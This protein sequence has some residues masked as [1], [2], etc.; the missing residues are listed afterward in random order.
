MRRDD[1]LDLN[2]ALQHP[3]RKIAV[4]LSTELPAEEDI[5]LVEPLE[6]FLEAVSTGNMLLITGEFKTKCVL[7]CSRCGAPIPQ[8]VAFEMDEQ[9]PVEGTPSTYA[10]DDYARVVP[11]EPFELFEGNNL[12]VENLLRQGLLVNLPMQALCQYGWEGDCP[13]AKA[14]LAEIERRRAEHP[15]EGLADLI[16]P[17]EEQA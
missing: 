16:K 9:F 11:D 6:G 14:R 17:E 3:G 8:E 7:E 13:E 2:D 5:D 12:M 1:L 4:D 10:A 15:L